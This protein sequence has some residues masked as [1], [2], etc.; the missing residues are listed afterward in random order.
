MNLLKE[1]NYFK[2]EVVQGFRE[3]ENKLALVKED[4]IEAGNVAREKIADSKN[5]E[6]IWAD[7]VSRNW[8][9]V[10]KKKN[11]LV[12]ATESNEKAT[13]MKNCVSQAL[14]GVQIS[15]ARFSRGGNIVIN[16]E[17]ENIRTEAA[18]KLEAV[19]KITTKSVWKLKPKIMICNMHKEE[20]SE[21]LEF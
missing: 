9:R 1:I 4:M 19:D 6:R 12:Q 11:L 3:L 14:A 2:D 7:V 16:F 15:D 8:K 21:M 13:D 18:Q 20:S 5:P 10:A 17:D